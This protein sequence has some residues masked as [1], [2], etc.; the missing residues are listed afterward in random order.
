ME[1]GNALF[2]WPLLSE[3]LPWLGW[4]TA[5]QVG[6][7]PWL[8]SMALTPHALQFCLQAVSWTYCLSSG[9]HIL[10][11]SLELF[12]STD[13]HAC[14]RSKHGFAAQ[15]PPLTPTMEQPRHTRRNGRQGVRGIQRWDEVSRVPRRLERQGVPLQMFTLPAPVSVAVTKTRIK[16]ALG[17]KGLFGLQSQFTILGKPRQELKQPG[18]PYPQSRAMKE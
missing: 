13:D 10:C 9:R 18:A 17:R 12:H 5:A 2:P 3:S 16:S 8:V 6:S 14:M 7:S 15:T 1:S 4:T 11:L